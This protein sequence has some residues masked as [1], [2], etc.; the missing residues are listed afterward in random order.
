M[1]TLKFPKGSKEKLS[2]YFV[3]SEFDCPCTECSVTLCDS[4]LVEKLTEVRR[5]IGRAIKITSGYR[6]ASYQNNL[7][8]R[9]Y[10]TATGVSQHELGRAADFVAGNDASVGGKELERLARAAGF[11]AVGVGNTFVHVDLRDDKERR[12]EYVTK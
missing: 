11:K 2:E 10:E 7:R 4:R 1:S 3:G 5:A 6:C 8:L 9:G 12:W